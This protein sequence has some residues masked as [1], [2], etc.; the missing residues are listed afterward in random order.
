MKDIDLAGHR[1]KRPASLTSLLDKERKEFTKKDLLDLIEK[2]GFEALNFRF[3]AGDG[4]LKTFNFAVRGRKH[5]DRLL[6]AGERVDG[7]SLFAYVDAGSSDL[8][9]VPRYETAYENPFTPFKTLDVLCSFFTNTGEPL[10]SSPENI[11]RRAHQALRDETGYELESLAELEYYVMS[12]PS[13]IYPGNS[14]RGYGE[15]S[16]FAKWEDLRLTAMVLLAQMGYPVKYG[17]SEVGKISSDTHAFEQAEIEF[18]LA[19]VERSADAVVVARWVLRQ[20]AARVGATVT[21]APKLMHGH[22]GSG[23]HVHT[24]L[25]KN[26]RCAI[27]D[28]SGLNDLARRLV[29]GY[30][31]LAPS[32]TAF[33]NPIPISYLRLVPN[34]EAPVYVCWGE[35]NRSV[36]VRAPLSWSGIEDMAAMANPQD[37][38][39]RTGD[40]ANPTLEFRSPDGSADIH[41]LHAGLA[42][43][44][45][46]GLK[47]SNALEVSRD[48][49][50]ETNIFREGSESHRE[51]LPKLPMSCGQ[52][53]DALVEQRSI[54]EQH[55]VFSSTHIDGI[56]KQLRGFG[57]E[58]ERCRSLDFEELNKVIS[59]YLHFP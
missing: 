29:A 27:G 37:R 11:V 58:E 31:T 18:D 43:A 41:L 52:S 34:Q 6:S 16:P 35:R 39:A 44:A 49:R 47:M 12:E 26:G 13:A 40:A 25:V 3:I 45:R 56:A 20:L 8:Y 53:A 46:H 7:S 2:E 23:L 9:V 51:R 14:Q 32:L 19:P 38:E 4:R 10:P 30:L 22:A 1:L 28:S 50:V 55:N 48:L 54:Y 36:L 57:L 5:V 59:Q 33:G 24:R 42:V 15:S 21:F 17:H